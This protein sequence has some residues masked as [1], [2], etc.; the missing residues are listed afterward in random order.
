M[1]KYTVIVPPEVAETVRHL[2]PALKS[3]IRAAFH[4]IAENPYQGKALKEE[5][6]GLFS[7]RVNRY[8][9][10][11]RIVQDK[12]QVQIV[13]LGRRINIYQRVTSKIKTN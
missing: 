13:D 2:P 1:K 11:Y 6:A 12:I 8:R 9:I 3:K 10:V 5:L 4:L 7:F